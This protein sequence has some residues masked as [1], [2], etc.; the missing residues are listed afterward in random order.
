MW[1][2]LCGRHRQT[3][4][5]DDITQ[6]T[7]VW[8]GRLAL[9]PLLLSIPSLVFFGVVTATFRFVDAP[10]MVWTIL[11]L[12]MTWAAMSAIGFIISTYLYKAST[13]M[14]NNMSNLPGLG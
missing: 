13:Y 12:V 9:A 14:L 8:L 10:T 5:N 4:P 11:T 1:Q 7:G 3:V 6:N 2:W